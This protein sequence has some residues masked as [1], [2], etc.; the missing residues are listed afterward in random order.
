M[1]PIDLLVQP[2]GEQQQKPFK[3]KAEGVFPGAVVVSGRGSGCADHVR[4]PPPPTQLVI[5]AQNLFVNNSKH[6]LWICVGNR[7]K[8]TGG[9]AWLFTPPAPN[10]AKYERKRRAA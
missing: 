10:L 2:W 5:W 4:T 8:G 1:A 6:G 3:V 9:T 7:E